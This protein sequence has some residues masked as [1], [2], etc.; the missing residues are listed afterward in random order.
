LSKVCNFIA[1]HVYNRVVAENDNDQ[2]DHEEE[3]VD[4][5][6]SLEELLGCHELIIN[7]FLDGI[8]LIESHVFFRLNHHFSQIKIIENK[9]LV[10]V[11]VIQ[12]LPN[13]HVLE[14]HEGVLDGYVFFNFR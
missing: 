12:F 5:H 13:D 6:E 3:N 7:D 1:I 8:L 14:I 4:V 10:G 9:F 11:R 2:R